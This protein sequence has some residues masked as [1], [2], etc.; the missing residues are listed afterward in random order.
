MTVSFQHTLNHGSL[1]VLLTREL[2]DL[3]HARIPHLA[4]FSIKGVGLHVRLLLVFF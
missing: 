4:K 2:G 1:L 3:S